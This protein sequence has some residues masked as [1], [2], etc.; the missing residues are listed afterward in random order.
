MVNFLVKTILHIIKAS[1]FAL[2][3]LNT[4]FREEFAFRIEV[5]LSLIALPAGIVIG[6]SALERVAL[7]SSFML[8]PIIELINTAIETTLNRISLEWH[9]L[10]KKAKDISSAAVML[11]V[12]NAAIVWLIII[13]SHD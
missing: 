3:G 10:I 5:W 4:A 7:I 11:T 13:F 9:E 12:F 2:A 6:H 1:R 8:I